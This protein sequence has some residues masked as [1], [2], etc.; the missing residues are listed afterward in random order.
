MAEGFTRDY[1][2]A[3]GQAGVRWTTGGGRIDLD[4]L[5]GRYVDGETPTS[6][7]VG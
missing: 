2:K 7:T 4:L 1:G 5:A 6:L 3:G